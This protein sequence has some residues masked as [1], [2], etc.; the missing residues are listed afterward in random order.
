MLASI[1]LSFKTASTEIRSIFA[2]SIQDI[3]DFGSELINNTCIKGLVI[4]STCNRSEFYFEYSNSNY[5]DITELVLSRLINF[6]GTDN[7]YQKYFY[8]KDEKDT[9]NHLFSVVCGF[10][11]ISLGEYQIVTQVKYAYKYSDDLSLNSKELKRLF[12]KSFET[13]KKIRTNTGINRGASS[14]SYAAIELMQTIHRD[15]SDKNVLVVGLG[16]TGGAIT[17]YLTKFKFNQLYISNRTY[18]KAQI[19]SKNLNAIPIKLEDIGKMNDNIDIYFVATSAP[20][21]II[22]KK[23]MENSTGNKTLIDIS[24]PRNIEINVGDLDSCTV[25][26]VDDLQEIVAHNNKRRKGEVQKG[27]KIMKSFEQEFLNW[28]S[29]QKL[30]NTISLIQNNFHQINSKE[31]KGFKKINKTEEQELLDKYGEHITNKY[32]RLL[33]KNIKTVSDNGNKKEIVEAINEVFSLDVN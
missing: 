17:E 26:D 33:I 16:Q 31:L 13:G 20:E 30:N 29:S 12:Q 25:Y 3:E 6:K 9:V 21:P 27:M 4:L 28:L 32:V 8:S 23:L 19:L 10:D 7:S 15:F 1:G 22:T 2:F 14:I 11:S 24:I 18:Y 5:E